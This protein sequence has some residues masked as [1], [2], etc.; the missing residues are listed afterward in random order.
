MNAY[1][2]IDIGGTAIKYGCATEEGRFLEKAS[3]P[4]Q[5]R[6]GGIP[7]KVIAIVQDMASR[8]ALAGVAIDTA[9]IVRPRRGW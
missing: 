9:G 8:H 6:E 3:C 7:E 4:T 1:A 5:A 2:V